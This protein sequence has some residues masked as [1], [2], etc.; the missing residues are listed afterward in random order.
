LLQDLTKLCAVVLNVLQ[1]DSQLT[2][3]VKQRIA[4]LENLARLVAGDLGLKVSDELDKQALR[5]SFA[6]LPGVLVHRLIA[7]DAAEIDATL[8]T[9]KSENSFE[10]GEKALWGLSL[11][12]AGF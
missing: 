5:L 7:R 11:R 6:Q 12:V 2:F 4:V 9:K 1:L 3:V 10:D 8:C